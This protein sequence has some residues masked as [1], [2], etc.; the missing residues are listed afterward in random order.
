MSTQQETGRDPS[1]VETQADAVRV[2]LEAEGLA[3]GDAIRVVEGGGVVGEHVAEA[4]KWRLEHEVRLPKSGTGF[5]RFEVR[6]S[7]G[8]EKA[9]S[10][11]IWFRR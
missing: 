11:P 5:V 7:E 8:R 6:T 3:P 10:N 9:F 1:R 2:V 4:D